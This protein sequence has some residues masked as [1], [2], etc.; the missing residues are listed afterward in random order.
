MYDHTRYL[1]MRLA[2]LLQEEWNIV[3]AKSY[4]DAVEE[5]CNM[6]IEIGNL[7]DLGWIKIEKM[8]VKSLLTYTTL[9]I[10]SQARRRM[11]LF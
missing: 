8:K 7:L 2:S 4:E 1:D 9:R 6:S 10:Q 5:I 11:T 3:K